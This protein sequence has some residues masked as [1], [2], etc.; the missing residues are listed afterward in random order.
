MLG[1]TGYVIL[2]VSLLEHFAMEFGHDYSNCQQEPGEE[3]DNIANLFHIQKALEDVQ[4]SLKV[5]N[6]LVEEAE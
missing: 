4:G 2:P 6:G 5:S 3:S 1:H